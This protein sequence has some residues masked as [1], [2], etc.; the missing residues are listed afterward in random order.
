MYA[1]LTSP[2]DALVV[3]WPRNKSAEDITRYLAHMREC[4]FDFDVEV[5]RQCGSIS[6][7]FETPSG[8]VP[9]VTRGKVT[10]IT[11][12][13][14][15]NNCVDAGSGEYDLAYVPKGR[16]VEGV[17]D[18]SD[19]DDLHALAAEGY[20]VVVQAEAV[21]INRVPYTGYVVRD[22]CDGEIREMAYEDPGAYAIAN[23]YRIEEVAVN[24]DE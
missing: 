14:H 15:W 10:Y 23:G 22:M 7:K 1:L 2:H 17:Y 3:A 21:L 9:H 18:T 8:C 11:A 12:D 13:G 16:L 24:G 20:R 4:P 5:S 19:I 6:I